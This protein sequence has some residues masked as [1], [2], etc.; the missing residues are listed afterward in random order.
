MTSKSLQ[1]QILKDAEEAGF[2]VFNG[3]IHLP[4]ACEVMNAFQAFAIIRE[5]RAIA[6]L[7]RDL[8][9]IKMEVSKVIGDW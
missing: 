7:V 9:K 4:A 5:N 6:P 2:K 3:T 8:N 1:A